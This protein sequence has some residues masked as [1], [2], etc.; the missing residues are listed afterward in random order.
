MGGQLVRFNMAGDQDP[1]EDRRSRTSNAVGSGPVRGARRQPGRVGHSH[2]DRGAGTGARALIALRLPIILLFMTCASGGCGSAARRHAQN[3]NSPS[4]DGRNITVTR[5]GDYGHVEPDVA[6][7]PRDARNLVGAVQFELGPGTRLPGTFTSFDSGQT[8]RDN[9]LL[10]LP[11][12]YDRGADTT[13]GF[14][15]HGHGFVVALLSHGGGGYPSRV[16]RGGVFLWRTDDGGRSFAKPLPVYVGPG[17]Q[18]HPWLAIRRSGDRTALLVAWTNASGLQLAVSE[19]DGSSFTSPRLLV[20]GSAPNTPVVTVGSHGLTRIFFE[21]FVQQQIRLRVLTSTDAGAHF[22]PAQTIGTVP[23]PPSIGGGPKGNPNVPPPLLAAATDPSG[24]D[25]VVAIA[26]EDPTAG[27][28]VIE[29]WRLTTATGQW[30]GPTQPVTG[31]NAIMSQQQPRAL[32]AD[33]QLYLSYFTESRDGLIREQ[34]AHAAATATQFRSTTLSDHA[35]RSNAFIGDYQAL[36]V[37]RAGGHALWND[38]RSGRLEIV[39]A[40][41]GPGR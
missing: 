25:S 13:V 17:F 30:H 14:D 24:A 9:G 2:A 41:F 23:R 28:Q 7:N 35:F 3:P 4:G 11:P 32:F 34:L 38:G 10:P 39:S 5:D 27:H 26:G 19:N 12:G 40:R 31:P 33:G 1:P 15:D 22:G 21:E 20:A 37:T 18:D 36:A 6:I 8:W 29:L 16:T